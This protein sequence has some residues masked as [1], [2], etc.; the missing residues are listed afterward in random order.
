MPRLWE[1]TIEAH[2]RTVRDATLDAA[3]TLV[4]E[5]GV[6]SL[7][8]SEIAAAAGIGRATLYKYFADVD[9]VLAAWHERLVSSHLAQLMRLREQ[10]GD[11]VTRLR[12]VLDAYAAIQSALPHSELAAQLHQG[13][14]IA[15][16]ERHLHELL[17][18]MLSEAVE[19]GGVRD[20]VA[21]DELAD[22]CLHAVTAAGDSR[23]KAAARRL[24]TV[25]MDALKRPTG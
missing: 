17:A 15:H 20:D 22:F 4:A 23:T 11:A 7:T 8:M 2:R 19:E 3:S 25:V 14:H 6:R 24:V 18:G 10:S 21:P 1:E 16:A 13:T 12:A 5:K 9:A